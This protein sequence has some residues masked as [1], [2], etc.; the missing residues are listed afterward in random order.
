MVINIR[1]GY[2]DKPGVFRTKRD[3]STK[4]VAWI[5]VIRIDFLR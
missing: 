1:A 3:G 5:P 2:G 4:R